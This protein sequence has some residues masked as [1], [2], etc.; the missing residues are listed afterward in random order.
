MAL[1]EAL[2]ARPEAAVA[3]ATLRH[4]RRPRRSR[5]RGGSRVRGTALLTALWLHRRFVVQSRGDARSREVDWVAVRRAA[6]AP[7]RGRR[8]RLLRPRLLR[9]LRRGGLLQAAARRRL[10]R[11]LRARR[12]ARWATSRRT[13]TGRAADRRAL[14]QPRPLHA[15]APLARRRPRRALADG[16][17][18][19][20]C[21]RW[22]RSCCPATTRAATPATPGRRCSRA[23]ARGWR[24]ARPSTTAAG[25]G[26][27]ARG[28]AGR[29]PT[30][31]LCVLL[32]PASLERLAGAR[33]GRGPAAARRARSAVEPA[34]LGYGATAGCPALMRERIAAG[35]ARR[36]ALPG[37][38]RAIVA[39]DAAQY[40]L[41]RALLA[42]PPRG[43]AL[44]RRR[45]SGGEL[46][47]RPPRA[48]RCASAASPA[49]ARASAT[50]RCSSAWRRWGSRAAGSAPSAAA[51]A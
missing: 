9:L 46:H 5:R 10:E 12:P 21:A 1:H 2:D 16:V 27:E 14:A 37:H 8:D 31:A 40:P 47:E 6:R 13:T 22:P 39:F 45:A 32:L 35:Q 20:R 34:A 25:G 17:H 49:A 42:A 26:C 48:R 30:A 7:R 43:G 3:G 19:R 41:A 38:P 29:C 44:V 18:L 24:S 51:A 4:P 15:Q 11:D 33:A 28:R 23:G 50:G 36:M